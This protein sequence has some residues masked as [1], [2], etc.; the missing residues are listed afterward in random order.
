MFGRKK[1]VSF[2]TELE[3]ALDDALESFENIDAL[4]EMVRTDGWKILEEKLRKDILNKLKMNYALDSEP[5]KNALAIQI[6][7][8]TIECWQRL[9]TV[10]HGT[11]NKEQEVLAELRRLAGKE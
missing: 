5:V 3:R 9:L 7:K 10:V 1:E 8:A 6:N 4:K 2:A 11:I